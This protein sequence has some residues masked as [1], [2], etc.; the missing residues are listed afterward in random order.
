MPIPICRYFL[1]VAYQGTYYHGWQVQQNT[2]TVQG[3]I[4]ECLAKILQREV[5]IVGSSRTDSGVH[6]KQQFAH[7]DLETTVD[8]DRLHYQLN[9]VLPP[10]VAITSMQ[11]VKLGTHARFSA[12]ARTYVYTIVQA[13]DPF[14]QQVS[15]WLRGTFDLRKMNEAAAILCCKKDF[16]GFSKAHSGLENYLC[17]VMEANWTTQRGQLIF[18]IKAN[19]FL[20]GMVRIIVSNLLQVGA[21]KLSVSAFEALIDQKGKNVTASLVPAGGLTLAAVAY[22]DGIFLA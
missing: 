13:K 17:T 15:Y 19:R 5:K 16:E 11:P 22:A 12:L 10:D 2:I 8:I 14:Q 20:R 9:A 1:E 7:I 4:Q 18:H 3:V 21:G 6:A